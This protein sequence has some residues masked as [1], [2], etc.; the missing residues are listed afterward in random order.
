LG[1]DGLRLLLLHHHE[2]IL[3]FHDLHLASALAQRLLIFA[4]E[5]IGDLLLELLDLLPVLVG[6]TLQSLVLS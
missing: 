5:K 3:K 2:L 1:L 6:L 4:L